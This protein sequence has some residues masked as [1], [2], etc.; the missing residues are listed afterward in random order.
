MTKKQTPAIV[1]E[2]L[3]ALERQ[4]NP[5]KAQFLQRFFKTG[6]GEYAEGDVLLGVTV[7]AQRKIAKTY[8]KGMTLEDIDHLLHHQW[9]EAR[10]TALFM[11]VQLYQKTVDTQVRQAI[12]EYYLDHT[13]YINNWDLVD[14][15]APYIVG[16]FALEQ[17]KTVASLKKMAQ[18]DD[19]WQ[20]RI[21]MVAMLVFVKAQEFELPLHQA[22]ILLHDQHD[23]I[24]KAVGWVL[25]EIGK[26]DTQTLKKFLDQHAATM[27]RTALRYAIERFDETTRQHYLQ[28]KHTTA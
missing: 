25:R 19:L 11:L 14:A 18:S 23:L 9:H 12:V 4:G 28:M 10:L 2:V 13:N 16:N 8:W 26:Q 15:S 6:P 27:P 3:E 22:T 7:P 17:P 5:T 21:S 20:K 24:H 1:S